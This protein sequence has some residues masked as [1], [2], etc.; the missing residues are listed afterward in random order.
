[1]YYGR[2]Y[3]KLESKGRVSLPAKFREK[4]SEGAILTRGL[5]GC[6]AIFDE[7]LW[8][9][10]LTEASQLAQTKKSHREY[11]R[12]L[13]ND[14]IELEIDQLGRIKIADELKNLVGIEKNVVFVGSLDHI[15]IWDQEKYHNYIEAVG[16]RI[17]ETVEQID[18]V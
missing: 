15:E 11:V 14:A 9:K 10:K 1:M 17:E 18:V 6:L 2:Y 4:L 8:Q 3:H 13:T 16:N 5:D 7:E 12:F